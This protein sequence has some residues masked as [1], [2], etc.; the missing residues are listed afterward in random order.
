[1]GTV[2]DTLVGTALVF[3]NAFPRAGADCCMA[4]RDEA[5]TNRKFQ[6]THHDVAG[7]ANENGPPMA[8]NSQ[9]TL[10]M[11]AQLLPLT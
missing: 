1:M 5:L 11:L 8:K 9:P 7:R 3:P 6:T 4:I 10:T 2:V